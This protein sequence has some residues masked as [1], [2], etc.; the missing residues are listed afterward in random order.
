LKKGKR[1]AIKGR[2]VSST[3]E[4][5]KIVEEAEVEVPARKTRKPP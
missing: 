3:Q 1:I 2:F 5:L 4:V